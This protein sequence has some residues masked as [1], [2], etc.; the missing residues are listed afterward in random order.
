VARRIRALARLRGSEGCDAER[1]SHERAARR[2]HRDRGLGWDFDAHGDRLDRVV[3]ARSP[4]S[5]SLSWRYTTGAASGSVPFSIPS[6]IPLGTYELRLFANDGYTRLATSNTFT[7]TGGNLTASP[8]GVAPGGSVTAGWSAIPAPTGTDWVGLY[9]PAGANTSPIRWQYTN[10][11]ASG[12]A[13]FAIP[14]GVAFGTYQLRLFSN[15]G[16]LHLATSN[17]LAVGPSVSGTVTLNGSPLA[18]VAFAGTNGASCTASNAS[19]Q[20][21]CSVPTGWSGSVTPSLAGHSFTP[22]S[23]S[24]TNVTANQTAQNYRAVVNPKVSGTVTLRGSPLAGVAFAASNGGTC[25]ASNASGLYSCSVPPGWSGS[26]TPSMSGY[27]FTP[28]SRSYSNVTADQT[29]QDYAV[30]TYDVSGT[31]TAGGLPLAGAGFTASNG[32]VC[33]ASNASGQYVCTVLPGWSGSVTPALSGYTFAPPSRSY[34]NV[35]A[36]QTAQDFAATVTTAAHLFFIHTDHLNTPR[37]VANQQG[38]TVWR[39][40]NAEPF[41]NSPPDENPSSLGA[42]EFPLRDE[43]TYFDKETNL[44][45]NWNRYRDPNDGRFIQADLLGL[46]GGDLSL[47]V[48][49]GNNPLSYIDPFGLQTAPPGGGA[50]GGL[51]GGSGAAGGGILGGSAG[52]GGVG[53]NK[54]IAQGLTNLINKIIEFCKPDDKKCPPC[55]LVDGTIVPIGTIGYRYD[56]P[57]QGKVEH[58]ISGPH[59]N[60]YKANQNLNNCQCFWQPIGAVPPPPQPDWIPIQPFAN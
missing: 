34:S 50:A 21:S 56:V 48:L 36:N 16:Y 53:S 31:V 52:A 14:A 26:V 47:Y 17:S 51:L 18:G 27:S 11:A 55:K 60:L 32:G 8:A 42:F 44:V 25:A 3:H 35:T 46:Y 28:A 10:G 2:Q 23:R 9:T 30:V 57:P 40:D 54:N 4:D 45:Y 38:Q 37:L 29:A 58:G 49:R 41:G 5:P 15:N 12:S 59:Y 20:Y 13:P 7:V 43:G 6:S 39:H 1:N 24:Y 22:A 19:G 33:T